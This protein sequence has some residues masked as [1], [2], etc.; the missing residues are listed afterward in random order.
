M[1]SS[2]VLRSQLQAGLLDVPAAAAQL[3]ADSFVEKRLEGEEGTLLRILAPTPAKEGRPA[4]PTVED[5][6]MAFI[7]KI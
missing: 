7:K 6:Y 2:L 1:R 3:P 4:E 5:G